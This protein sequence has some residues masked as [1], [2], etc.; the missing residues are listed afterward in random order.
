MLQRLNMPT[1]HGMYGTPTYKTWQA[2]HGRCRGR[3]SKAAYYSEKGIT[4]CT[5]WADFANFYADMGE[6]P[7]GMTLDRIDSSLGY[8]PANCRWA[9]KQMQMRNKGDN[10]WIEHDGQRKCLTE[11]ASIVG[12]ERQTLR[13]RMSLGWPLADVL[14]SQKNFRYKW[15][16]ALKREGELRKKAA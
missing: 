12:V 3:L 7:A 10:V 5:A 16:S 8:S 4:V 15:R 9:T 2:M 11:W 14:N 13:K 6:R 1:K